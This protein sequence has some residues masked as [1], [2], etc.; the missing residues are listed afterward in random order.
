MIG[1]PEAIKK[2]P[3][4]FSCPAISHVLA[5]VGPRLE[6]E[7]RGIAGISPHEL[8]HNIF[9]SDLLKSFQTSCPP[10]PHVVGTVNKHSEI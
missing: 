7:R 8:S 1:I 6:T 3:Y 9:P 4:V 2:V 5:S 10:P